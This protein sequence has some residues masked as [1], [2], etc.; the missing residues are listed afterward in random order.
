M[1]VDFVLPTYNYIESHGEVSNIQIQL[2]N[3][4]AQS[5]EISYNGGE[6]MLIL[7]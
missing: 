6:I 5:L 1:T 7:C 3:V 2:S 4:I